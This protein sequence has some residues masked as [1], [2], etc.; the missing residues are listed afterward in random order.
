MSVPEV[1][2]K[3]TK[4]EIMDALNAALERENEAKRLKANPMAEEKKK[5]EKKVV[6][7]TKKAVEQN[8]FSQELI[9]KFIELEKA[10]AVE[11]M[12]LSELYGVEKELQNLTLAVNAGKDATEKIES[13]KKA[14]TAALQDVIQALKDDYAQKN[15]NLRKEYEA[16]SKALKTERDREAEEYEYKQKRER[17]LE[18]NKWEDSKSVREAALAAKEEKATQILTEAQGKADYIAE[19][20]KKVS[21]IPALI[22]KEV[23]SAVANTK[24]DLNRDFDYK[25]ALA[26]KDYTNTIAQLEYKVE[27]LLQELGKES[28][29]VES[30]QVKLDK[31]YSDMRELAG[32]TVETSGGVRFI[33]NPTTD[34]PQ[35]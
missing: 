34:K 29:L 5:E 22:E 8:I 23:A 1:T 19:L 17:T 7:S 13:D 20:E 27:S 2:L 4:A 11:E 15:E 32:K 33:N 9:D 21:G 31:A 28:A 10:I 35:A 25:F 18:N 16:R 30:L 24:K 12:R 6:E 3:N 26:G 14:Q